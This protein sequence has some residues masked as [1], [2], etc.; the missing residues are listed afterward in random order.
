MAGPTVRFTGGK[1]KMAAGFPIVIDG[2]IVGVQLTNPGSG[3]QSPTTVTFQAPSGSGTGA[4]GTALIANGAVVHVAMTSSG[5]GYMPAL[6]SRSSQ[7]PATLMS[8]LS[9]RP[10]VR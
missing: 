5:S 8:F 10:L 2:K 9:G 4:T 6:L 1:G 3:Y 7:V